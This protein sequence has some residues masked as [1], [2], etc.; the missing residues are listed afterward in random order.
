MGKGKGKGVAP[1]LP[2]SN[3]QAVNY[4]EKDG[5]AKTKKGGKLRKFIGL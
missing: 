3:Q 1:A 5:L 2:T 4:S